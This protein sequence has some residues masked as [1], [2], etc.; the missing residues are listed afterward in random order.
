MK[1]TD[2]EKRIRILEDIEAIKKIKA[3]YWY[4]LER[5]LWDELPD[6][7]ATDVIDYAGD[8]I[9]GCQGKK[10]VVKHLVDLLDKGGVNLHRGHSPMIDITSDTTAI[11][12]WDLYLYMEFDPQA[13]KGQEGWGSYEDEYVKE[14]GKWKIK[15]WKYKS[16]RLEQWNKVG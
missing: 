10:D 6:V 1:E 11:G 12:K 13:K 4:C 15:S 9:I 2:L 8:N 16:A 7:F 14:D 5:R 3:K